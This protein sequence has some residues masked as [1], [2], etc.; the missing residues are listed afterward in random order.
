MLLTDP[1]RTGK[2]TSGVGMAMQFGALKAVFFDVDGVLLDSLPQHLKFCADKA[3]EYGLKHLAIPTVHDFKRMIAE[4]VRVS[5]MV[6][7][8]RALGFPPALAER[9]TRDYEEQFM[10]DYRP[11]LFPG[12]GN[13]LHALRDAGLTLGL[14]TSNTR[15]NVE[16]AL[17]RFMQYFDPRCLFYF[18][19]FPVAKSKNACLIEGTRV[20]NVSPS[21]CCYIGDQPA[22]QI[23]AHSA[24]FEFLGVSYGW[25]FSPDDPRTFTVDSPSAIFNALTATQSS[26][27]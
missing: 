1:K 10:P 21:D 16:P 18:D 7:F 15:A 8:F 22:D 9:G 19:S 5:P 23:A 3:H 26:R 14:V 20:L 27:H 24:G 25:G 11:D 2:K 4:G 17:G 13:L 12:A 6:E